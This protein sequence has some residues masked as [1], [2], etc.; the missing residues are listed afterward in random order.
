MPSNKIDILEI[1]S[2]YNNFN[3]CLGKFSSAVD[4]VNGVKRNTDQEVLKRDGLGNKLSTLVSD[5]N[6]VQCGVKDIMSVLSVTEDAYN[7]SSDKLNNQ[8]NSFSTINT[9]FNT[10]SINVM[11]DSKLETNV[12]EVNKITKQGE[13]GFIGPLPLDM[14]FDQTGAVVVEEETKGFFDWIGE[15]IVGAWDWTSEKLSSAWDWFT[16]SAL[17]KTAASV[18]V[19]LQSLTKGVL[20]LVEAL[21]D[22][23][24]LLLTGVA[25]IGTGI[26]DG[27]QAIYGAITGNEWESVTKKMWEGTQ[28]AVSYEWVDA[29][30][31]D[32]YANNPL[33]KWL[34]ETS[35]DW[36]KPD[37]TAANVCEGIGY[38]AGVIL[39]SIVTAGTGTAALSTTTTGTIISG[40]AGMGRGTE[41]AWN[42]GAGT[43]EGLGIGTLDGLWEAGQW[44]AGAKIGGAQF[45]KVTGQI[46]NAALKKITISGGHIA[47]DTLTGAVEVPYQALKSMWIKDISYSEAWE[48]TGGTDALLTQSLIAGITSFGGEAFD[49]GGKFFK[50]SKLKQKL[51]K[52]ADTLKEIDLNNPASYTSKTFSTKLDVA[53]YF[54]DPKLV[55]LD[56]A[57]NLKNSNVLDDVT[58]KNINN[59]CSM[60]TVDVN[61]IDLL[62][63]LSP[64]LNSSEINQI[65][66]MMNDFDNINLGE[67]Q[68]SLDINSKDALYCYTKMG[69]FELNSCLNKMDCFIDSTGKKHY[70]FNNGDKFVKWTDDDA[71]EQVTEVIYKLNG[72]S[73]LGKTNN[74]VNE[75]DNAI[76]TFNLDK[77]IT[78]YRGINDLGSSVNMDDLFVGQKFTTAG[79][80]SCTMIK[81]GASLARNK[82][83]LLEINV[84]SGNHGAFIESMSG[85]SDYCQME[86]LLKRN[87]SFEITG[88]KEVNGKKIIT[89]DLVPDNVNIKGASSAIN[90]SDT[91]ITAK[92]F[93]SDV[94]APLNFSGK[95]YNNYYEFDLDNKE[96]IDN[97]HKNLTHG[98]QEILVDYKG[99]GLVSS[100]KTMNAYKRG[101]LFD[102]NGN[103]CLTSFGTTTKFT[104]DEYFQLTGVTVDKLQKK[105]QKECD[106]LN[107]TIK[108]CQ[109]QEPTVLYRGVDENFIQDLLGLDSFDLNDLKALEGAEFTEFGFAS[110]SPDSRGGFTNKKIVLE[111]NV[112]QGTGFAPLGRSI[113]SLEEEVLLESGLKYTIDSVEEKGNQYIVHMIQK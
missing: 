42:S 4:V 72:K 68:N 78:V 100:Y 113:N 73:T 28:S 95:R 46:S 74:I 26:V 32:Y 107:K 62:N 41:D 108:K 92:I 3:S 103:V 111:L 25:S 48:Q 77:P 89:C 8:L 14:Q 37:S 11:N 58:R 102:K 54:G 87:S 50:D 21:G 15:Q 71:L 61:S 86:F 47:L 51:V 80:S 13:T 65:V 112:K 104:P 66:Q 17:G 5:I 82:N 16:D 35:Y 36:A 99:E 79:Y 67:W 24:L 93:D 18:E 94:T 6:V 101:T 19:L 33:G 2:V 96:I 110:T 43:L 70:G 34:S 29:M 56:K 39:L 10:L 83:Y 1:H 90:A 9:S 53:D 52:N 69:G 85:V 57:N 91:E 27:C 49:I 7:A 106:L 88:I 76:G 75:L 45:G 30:F 55:L 109:L 38:V 81:D 31:D 20:D 22:F 98:E 63:T 97:W 44:Y 12:F 105:V 23:A 60:S 40:V 84:P 64:Y 59:F